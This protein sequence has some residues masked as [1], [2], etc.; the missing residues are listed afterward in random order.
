MLHHLQTAKDFTKIFLQLHA[1]VAL[2][3]APMSGILSYCPHTT[4]NLGLHFTQ[5][6]PLSE[7]GTWST[8]KCF[9]RT[10]SSSALAKARQVE[11]TPQVDAATL[12]K[13]HKL[14][15]PV[16]VLAGVFGSFV[17]VGGGVLIVPML[18]GACKALPQRL[19][20]VLMCPSA[21]L[22]TPICI[23]ACTLNRLPSVSVAC[24]HPDLSP[25]PAYLACKNSLH[26]D[27]QDRPDPHPHLRHSHVLQTWLIA[28]QQSVRTALMRDNALVL[29]AVLTAA[30]C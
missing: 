25:R 23:M 13:A 10:Y 21:R 7:C 22:R 29:G 18:T 8:G 14:S 5:L 4:G 28:E 1:A 6:L 12:A 24:A 20:T 30:D 17:G 9:E 16:G 15:V 11:G 19:L 2:V 26:P 27:P 3:L